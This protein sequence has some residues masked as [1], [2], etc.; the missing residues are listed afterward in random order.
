MP[1]P[2]YLSDTSNLDAQPDAAP[3]TKL[4][5]AIAERKDLRP[6]KTRPH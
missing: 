5:R 1:I 3:D 4:R 6:P 2:I